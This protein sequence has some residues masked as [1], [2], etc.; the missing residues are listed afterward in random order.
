MKTLSVQLES[1]LSN[2]ANNDSVKV[3]EIQGPVHH[4]E[5]FAKEICKTQR[6]S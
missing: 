4:I 1:Q 5:Q 3:E 2:R 6:A